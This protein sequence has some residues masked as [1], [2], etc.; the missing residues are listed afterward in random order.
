LIAAHPNNVNGKLQ[1][2]PLYASFLGE[3]NDPRNG[4]IVTR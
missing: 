3:G 1:Q 4:T 2:I